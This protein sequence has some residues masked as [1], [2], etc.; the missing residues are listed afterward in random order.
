MLWDAVHGLL[1]AA[2]RLFH[3]ATAIDADAPNQP[4]HSR[5]A[6]IVVT[7][8]LA[9]GCF[10][11]FRAPNFETLANF[12][13]SM[14]RPAGGVNT[15]PSIA[16]AALAVAA[17]LEWTPRPWLDRLAGAYT[18]LPCPVQAGVVTASLFTF[19]AL[20]GTGAPFIYFQF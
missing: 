18:R 16:Y 12:F 5:L 13:V 2:G 19:G 7:F 9:A 6:R 3:A 15:V 4:L 14:T 10:V 20:A 17:L 8:H 11:M 1:L